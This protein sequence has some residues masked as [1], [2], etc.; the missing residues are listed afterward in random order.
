MK[1]RRLV[2]LFPEVNPSRTVRGSCFAEQ[3]K[4]AWPCVLIHARSFSSTPGVCSEHAIYFRAG[5]GGRR[6]VDVHTIEGNE[7]LKPRNKEMSS[8]ENVTSL[9]E[10]VKSFLDQDMSI[11]L[12]GG[13]VVYGVKFGSFHLPLDGWKVVLLAVGAVF[14]IYLLTT[15]SSTYKAGKTAPVSSESA[16]STR[17]ATSSPASSPAPKRQASRE[18]KTKSA[19]KSQSPE[20]P[21]AASPS[22]QPARRSTRGKTPKK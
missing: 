8:A 3:P 1:E 10:N 11:Q 9:W 17:S 6:A 4:H 16:R 18:S 21:R 13:E 7:H 14:F 15:K 2:G 5:T 12:P 22:P 20:K 19:P